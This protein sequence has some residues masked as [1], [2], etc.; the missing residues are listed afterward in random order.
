HLAGPD[1]QVERL[2]RRAAPVGVGNPTE[3][4]NHAARRYG[5]RRPPG[6]FADPDPAGTNVLRYARSEISFKA[7]ATCRSS[8]R[9]APIASR[10]TYRPPA[11]V[12]VR[13]TWPVAFTRRSRSSLGPSGPRSR[14]QT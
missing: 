7:A 8:G 1:G 10:R 4:E 11:F 13:Y 2:D 5:R 9:G 12:C 14:K 3:F 6:R